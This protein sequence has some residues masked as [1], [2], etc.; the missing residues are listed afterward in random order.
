MKPGDWTTPQWIRALAAGSVLLALVLGV[1]LATVTSGVRD[2]LAVIGGRAAPQVS[3][4]TDLSFALS[5]MDAQLAN[6]MLVG[7]DPAFTAIHQQSLDL[8][9]QRRRQADADLQQVATDESAQQAV[10]TVLDQFG[11][12]QA[13]ASQ[14]LLLDQ[15]GAAGRPGADV[16]AV[17]RQATGR[18]QDTLSAVRGLTTA[19]HD[20]LNSTY[21]SKVDDTVTART[22]VLVIGCTLVLLLVVAQVYLRLKLRRR[23]TVALLLATLLGAGLTI[24]GT[25]V[26]ADESGHLTV[27]KSNAFDSIVA[28]AQARAVSYDANADESRYLVDP[29]L[30]AKCQQSF[31]D[32]S[33]QLV[34]LGADLTHYDSALADAL[35]AYQARNSDVRFTGFFGT[36]LNNITFPGERAAAEKTLAAYQVYQLDDRKI[37][38]MATTGDLRAAILFCISTSPG[39]SNYDFGQYDAALTALIAI[40]QHAFDGAIADGDRETGG[41]TGL[42]PGLTVLLL[43]AS[44]FVGVRPRLAEYR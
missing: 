32:K 44:V 28:L 21:Q 36:E 23:L 8:F 29:E 18:M 4:T 12:Y 6:V 22:W 15:G 38:A 40:N 17:Y 42:I 5:D 31:V 20:L 3:A 1:V 43:A 25:V 9:D 27:A 13:L 7:A 11:Q 2:G 35:R 19:N 33:L 16:L 30:A 39:N 26:L 10:R 24:A 41:W 34:G 14:V 37:R